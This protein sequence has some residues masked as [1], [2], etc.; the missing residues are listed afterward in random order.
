ML[1]LQTLGPE[2]GPQHPREKQMTGVME[3][4]CKPSTEGGAEWFVGLAALQTWLEL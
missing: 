4:T 1:D 2:L 3:H